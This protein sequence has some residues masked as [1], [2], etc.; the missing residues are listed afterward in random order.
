MLQINL[1]TKCDLRLLDE[2]LLRHY[3]SHPFF[4]LAI[5]WYKGTNTKPFVHVS[6]RTPKIGRSVQ[7]AISISVEQTLI[8]LWML[9]T[10]DVCE[11]P[12]VTDIARR[13]DVR[14]PQGIS[15]RSSAC[16]W[17]CAYQ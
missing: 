5:V 7:P 10:A 1:S 11:Y 4:Y 16:A 8:S 2:N 3:P 14:S 17:T 6:Q 9:T 15:S 12:G 13:H